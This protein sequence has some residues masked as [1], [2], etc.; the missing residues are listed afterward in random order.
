V[1]FGI[2]PEDARRLATTDLARS[3]QALDNA[4]WQPAK[5]LPP[6][7]EPRSGACQPGDLAVGDTARKEDGREYRVTGV[8]DDGS[9]AGAKRCRRQ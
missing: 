5:R 4:D 9:G 3:P 1:I 7:A 6:A 8:S 2:S